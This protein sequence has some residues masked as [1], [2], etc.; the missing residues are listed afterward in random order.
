MT[1]SIYI[2]GP[3]AT[4]PNYGTRFNAAE[5]YLAW[6][7]WTVLNPAWLPK[8]LRHET[9]MP[10]CLAMLNAADAI[11]MLEGHL[12]SHGARIEGD[13]A[14]YQGKTIYYGIEEVP[15]ITDDG[16]AS[17]GEEVPL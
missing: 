13:F 9:Y 7:G 16:L 6:K 11:C 4:D 2:A 10:I 17:A 5:S 12:N 8:G 14:G 3:M 15:V 1:R